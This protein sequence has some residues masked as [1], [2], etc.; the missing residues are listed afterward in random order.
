MAEIEK[1]QIHHFRP[2]SVKN[3]CKYWRALKLTWAITDLYIYIYIYIYI[4]CEL[5]KVRNI[6]FGVGSEKL[7]NSSPLVTGC[8]IIISAWRPWG[9]RAD[10]SGDVGTVGGDTQGYLCSRLLSFYARGGQPGKQSKWQE[11][12]GRDWKTIW[13]QIFNGQDRYFLYVRCAVKSFSQ[14]LIRRTT[15]SWRSAQPCVTWCTVSIPPF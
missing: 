10:K 5:Y 11:P 12:G 1:V 15:K 9:T 2:P 8:K 3:K 6:S 13:E 4:K 14:T 7:C